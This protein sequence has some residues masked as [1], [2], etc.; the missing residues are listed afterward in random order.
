M[1]VGSGRLQGLLAEA[2]ST[3]VLHLSYLGLERVP[4]EVFAVEGLMR[5]DLGHNNI[6]EL[7]EAVGQLA[8]CVSAAKRQETV[9]HPHSLVSLPAAWRSCG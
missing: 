8:R 6:Q 2:Q 9:W 3:H 5:L 7:P 4:K 1:D